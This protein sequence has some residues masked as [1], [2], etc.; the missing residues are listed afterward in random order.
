MPPN[1]ADTLDDDHR[2][3][4][5][6]GH[7]R[8]FHGEVESDLSQA[9]RRESIQARSEMLAQVLRPEPVR[10]MV[11]RAGITSYSTTAHNDEDTVITTLRQV[12]DLVL[13]NLAFECVRLCAHLKKRILTE[14][15]F[16][17][18][19]KTFGIKLLGDC[20][21]RHESCQTLKQRREET[22]DRTLRGA[23]A[24]IHHELYSHGPCLYF[25]HAPFVRAV[26]MYLKEQSSSEHVKAPAGVISCCQLVLEQ[27]LIEILK[28]SRY[29]VRQTTRQKTDASQP[30]RKTVFSRDIKTVLTVL[31]HRHPILQGRMRPVLPD[32][33]PPPRRSPRGSPHGGGGG[34]RGG[35]AHHSPKAKASPARAKAAARAKRGR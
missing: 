4:A 22:G 23:E 34:R 1:Q 24:E 16:R 5:Q 17:E 11:R 6:G 29:I 2:R 30:K 35:A 32:D 20:I 33:P 12:A 27:T 28:A 18:A 7:L 26:R 3:S 10:R 15:L 9:R 25:A 8:T 21:E 31:A 13:F 14:E 19:L